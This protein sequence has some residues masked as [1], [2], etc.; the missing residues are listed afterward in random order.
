MGVSNGFRVNLDELRHAATGVTETLNAM[1]TKKVSDI[2]APAAAFGH[3]DLASAVEEFCDRWNIG[4]EHLA[5]DGAE[6]ADRLNRCVQAYVK[7]E[8]H[9]Q[10]S[11][12]GI[13]Q[14]SA[15]TD[16]GAS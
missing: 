9:I 2:D 14:D 1:A 3:D 4:V 5:K 6:V 15:G 7:A 12:E 11:T 16:P 13:L 8:E 10:I